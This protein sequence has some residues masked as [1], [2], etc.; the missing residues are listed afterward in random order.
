MKILSRRFLGEPEN[1]LLTMAKNNTVIG[2]EFNHEELN[3][4]LKKNN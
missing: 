2:L 1:V 4:F 3:N